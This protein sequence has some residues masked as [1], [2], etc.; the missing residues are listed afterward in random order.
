M[1]EMV[2]LENSSRSAVSSS[3]IKKKCIYLFILESGSYQ[4]DRP[5]FIALFTTNYKAMEWK[6]VAKLK[7]NRGC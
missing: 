3:N 7:K 2:L 5:P 6:N 1:L 4:S